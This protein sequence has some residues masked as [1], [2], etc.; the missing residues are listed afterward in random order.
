[1]KENRKHY[2]IVKERIGSILT[3][4]F[5]VSV[6]SVIMYAN[7]FYYLNFTFLIFMIPFFLHYVIKRTILRDKSEIPLMTVVMSNLNNGFTLVST[8]AGIAV[9][10]VMLREAE[11]FYWHGIYLIYLIQPVAEFRRNLREASAYGEILED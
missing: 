1:M 5:L 4:E 2:R 11:F 3:D 10:M 7:C 8:M 9:M 6:F